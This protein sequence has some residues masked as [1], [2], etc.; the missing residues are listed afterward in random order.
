MKTLVLVSLLLIGFSSHSQKIVILNNIPQEVPKN[1]KWVISKGKDFLVQFSVSGYTEPFCQALANQKVLQRIEEGSKGK[2]STP[3]NYY[4]VILSDMIEVQTGLFKVTPLKIVSGLL[5][6]KGDGVSEMTFW[7]GERVNLNGCLFEM[8]IFEYESNYVTDVAK[9]LQDQA[10]F[11]RQQLLEKERKKKEEEEK[12]LKL[13]LSERGSAIYDY[14]EVDPTNYSN[15]KKAIE[16]MTLNLLNSYQDNLELDFLITSE[17]DTSK[18]TSHKTIAVNNND[19]E[20]RIK[21]GL[22]QI[23]IEPA[24]K[25]GYTVNTKTSF[26]IH[27]SKEKSQFNFKFSDHET[28][29]MERTEPKNFINAKDFI[30]AEL[31]SKQYPEG[32]YRVEYMTMSLNDKKEQ[33]LKVVEFKGLGGIPCGFLSLAVPGAGDHFVKGHGS[34]FGK[35]ISPWATTISSIA[36]VGTG[37]YLKSSSNKN[38]DLYHKSTTQSDI[39]KYYDLADDQNKTAFV[40]IAAGAIIWL[41]DVIWVTVQG[42]R[43][44]KTSNAFKRKTG[45]AFKPTL[46]NNNDIGMSVTLKFK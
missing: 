20:M 6:L 15:L 17:I 34:M 11:E 45:L 27:C 10:N 35:N 26:K 37:F 18:I 28:F 42:N 24:Y 9:T 22:D 43:N 44:T 31:T 8:Q 29:F 7:P 2:F 39:D 40:T 1:K 25:S 36:L 19:F 16:I 33:N 32:K 12:Q 41:S 4:S 38:Y 14:K 46:L 3:N 23:K 30:T 5:N 13:F 21:A